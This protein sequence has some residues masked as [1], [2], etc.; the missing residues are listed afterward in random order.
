MGVALVAAHVEGR[1]KVIRYTCW[2]MYLGCA[3]CDPIN[4]LYLS[5]VILCQTLNNMWSLIRNCPSHFWIKRRYYLYYVY[6]CVA[7]QVICFY[8]LLCC[9]CETGRKKACAYYQFRLSLY[10]QNDALFL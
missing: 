3:L 10:R 5:R 4:I 8:S 9:L 7:L 1:L 6:H 2:K